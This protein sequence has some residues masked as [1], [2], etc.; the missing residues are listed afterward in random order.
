MMIHDRTDWRRLYA[1]AALLGGGF[2]LLL[3]LGLLPAAPAWPEGW[4]L[5]PISAG[6]ALLL[7]PA[8]GALVGLALAA[9]AHLGVRWQ[10]RRRTG[11]SA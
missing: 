9:M 4:G 3:A 2:G 7:P 10:L 11:P 6:L 8:A 1:V 5:S